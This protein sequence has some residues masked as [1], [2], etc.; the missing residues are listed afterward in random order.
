MATVYMNM[1]EL[2]KADFYYSEAEKYVDKN[3]PYYQQ[4]FDQHSMVLGVL[5]LKEMHKDNK[6]K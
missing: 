1:N 4:L 2:E 3:S 5:K 6:E